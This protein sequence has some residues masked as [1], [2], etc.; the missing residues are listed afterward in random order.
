MLQFPDD[1]QVSVTGLD[2]IM[3]GLYLEEIKPTDDAAREMIT[4]LEE[5]GN[6]IPSSESVHREYAYVLLREYKKFVRDRSAR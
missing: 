3:A 6:F 2:D 5:K 4:R 1:T